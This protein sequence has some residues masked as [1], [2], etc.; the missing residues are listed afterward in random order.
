MHDFD[1]FLE[2]NMPSPQSAFVV[3]LRRHHRHRATLKNIAVTFPEVSLLKQFRCVLRRALTDFRVP[4]KAFKVFQ[5]TSPTRDVTSS[6][7]WHLLSED[8]SSTKHCCRKSQRHEG[9]TEVHSMI[10]HIWAFIDFHHPI[11]SRMLLWQHQCNENELVILCDMTFKR[12][13]LS[14][15]HVICQYIVQTFPVFFCLFVGKCELC[16]HVSASESDLWVASDV[17]FKS[18][19]SHLVLVPHQTELW[20]QNTLFDCALYCYSVRGLHRKSIPKKIEKNPT[21]QK[22]CKTKQNLIQTLLGQLI[23]IC[24]RNTHVPVR[25]RAHEVNCI[26]YVRGKCDAQNY[27]A[28]A[29]FTMCPCALHDTLFVVNLFQKV[30]SCVW[31]LF[32]FVPRD[33]WELLTQRSDFQCSWLWRPRTVWLEWEMSTLRW[34]KRTLTSLL[35]YSR[36]QRAQRYCD[37]FVRPSSRL[38]KALDRILSSTS[39][40]KTTWC[41]TCQES[42]PT[43]WSLRPF[44][45]KKIVEWNTVDDCQ[46]CYLVLGICCL[47]A[48]LLRSRTRLWR[49]SS[50][51]NH[52]PVFPAHREKSQQRIVDTKTGKVPWDQ[53]YHQNKLSITTTPPILRLLSG[54]PHLPSRGSFPSLWWR[55]APSD[56]RRDWYRTAGQVSRLPPPS[57][58]PQLTGPLLGQVTLQSVTKTSL[59]MK[60]TLCFADILTLLW[61]ANFTTWVFSWSIL[62]QSWR[63]VL[64]CSSLFSQSVHKLT[65]DHWHR[66]SPRRKGS[67]SQKNS[68]EISRKDPQGNHTQHQET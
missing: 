54:S 19:R 15:A 31:H 6:W 34:P 51:P 62:T 16:V 21:C 17:I 53:K 44:L 28:C 68:S 40:K 26:I 37:A 38:L 66:A 61:K 32:V 1:V 11:S 55:R 20:E 10:V 7:L 29:V 24:N 14:C 12:L 48:L 8:Q 36:C 49:S 57:P 2:A 50:S 23:S 35:W 25:K 18:R 42:L 13:L 65:R 9:P 3:P 60:T 5:L 41:D 39:K 58:P 64:R 22:K 63:A 43:N 59:L 52:L 46:N 4:L 30:V 47:P 67:S 45:Q 27:R 33:L 56:S